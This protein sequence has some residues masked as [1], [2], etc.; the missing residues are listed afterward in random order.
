MIEF[1]YDPDEKI[2]WWG[3]S[4]FFIVHLIALAGPF[5]APPTW[6]LVGLAVALY[7]IRMWAIVV[8][9]H[10]YFSHRSFKTSRAF[11]LVLAV[12]GL[13]S[14]QKGPLWWA[15]HHRH[16]HRHSDQEPDLHSPTLRGFLWA[17]MGWILCPKYHGTEHHK[18][19]DFMKYPEL[20]WL[21]RHYMAVPIAMGAGLW[22]FAGFEAFI[23]GGMISTVLL[24]H[25]TFTINS[26]SHVFGKRRFA[27]KDTSKN[28]FWL[29]LITLGEGWHNNHHYYPG[30][31]RQG[32]YW[33]EVD[34]G[35]YS[36]KALE[37]VGI[38]WDVNAVPERVLAKGRRGPE[39][40]SDSG[41]G[42]GGPERPE[43]ALAAGG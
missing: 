30:S 24:W 40:P 38:V 1:E 5:L 8:G 22:I 20:R 28:N 7:L 15:A 33:W 6:K 41:S 4:P 17:H 31:A 43:Q 37:R 35:Y 3:S 42:D 10:R 14:A 25:G 27:T 16:H 12:V 29:A 11:Q 19:R 18:I 21:D 34:I 36:I 23:W 13:A 26:L 2:N 32:F 39:P 9:Y